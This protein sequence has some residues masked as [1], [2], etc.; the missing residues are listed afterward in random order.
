MPMHIID[1]KHVPIERILWVSDIPH[2]CGE[3]DCEVEGKY[4]VRLEMDES[5]FANRE[6]RDSVIEALKDLYG[7]EEE[8]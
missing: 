2:F 1:D 6:Q 5:L 4:E 7:G 8:L 3:D